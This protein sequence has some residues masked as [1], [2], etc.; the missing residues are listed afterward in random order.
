[1]AKIATHLSFSRLFIV[2]DDDYIMPDIINT[3]RAGFELRFNLEFSSISI[4]DQTI[5]LILFHRPT[6]ELDF[7]KNQMPSDRNCSKVL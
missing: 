3:K 2:F 1:M 5:F 6:S 4:Y 7:S